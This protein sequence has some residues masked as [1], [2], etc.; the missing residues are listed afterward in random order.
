MKYEYWYRDGWTY[1]FTK[2]EVRRARARMTREE[3]K[4]RITANREV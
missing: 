2:E 1:K 3:R 4:L